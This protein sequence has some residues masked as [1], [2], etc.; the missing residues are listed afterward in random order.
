MSIVRRWFL[1]GGA[2]LAIILGF[3]LGTAFM[4]NTINIFNN[5]IANSGQ[6]VAALVINLSHGIKGILGWIVFG[7]TMT[8]ALIVA[9]SLCLVIM[10]GDKK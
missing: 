8:N 4:L 7:L 9:S 2:I 3:V 5:A 6:D 1:L 10:I